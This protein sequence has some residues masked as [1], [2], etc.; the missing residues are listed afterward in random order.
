M[1]RH[2][3]DMKW[4]FRKILE[5]NRFSFIARWFNR[6]S[7]TVVYMLFFINI[8]AFSNT[9]NPINRKNADL[10]ASI[11]CFERDLKI[12]S[13]CQSESLT[14]PDLSTKDHTYRL[15]LNQIND[16]NEIIKDDF[17]IHL[18][19]ANMDQL[20]L[21]SAVDTALLTVIIENSAG[22]I[23]LWRA[24]YIV[25]NMGYFCFN[26]YLVSNRGDKIKVNNIV[27][28]FYEN[29]CVKYINNHLFNDVFIID[30][31]VVA[32]FDPEIRYGLHFGVG[33][34]YDLSYIR[35]DRKTENH[36]CRIKHINHWF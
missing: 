13:L 20:H 4:W 24:K 34:I 33:S 32:D 25:V 5:Y 29:C 19:Y 17:E 31:S 11:E 22:F 9:D 35:F 12:S 7:W 27:D 26:S 1:K 15:M 8:H 14:F 28:K 10:S 21:N 18:G 2:I 36:N 30:S 23:K 16:S 3:F 6:L